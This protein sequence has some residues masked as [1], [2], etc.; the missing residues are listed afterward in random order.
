[1]G[2]RAER[3]RRGKPYSTA[4]SSFLHGPE[5]SERGDGP[6]GGENI[7][8]EESRLKVT[9]CVTVIGEE[10]AAAALNAGQCVV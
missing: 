9:T 6:E 8:Q 10:A 3:L 7:R 1:M 5:Q 2:G 4:V